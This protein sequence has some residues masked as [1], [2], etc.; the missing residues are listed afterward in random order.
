MTSQFVQ[1]SLVLIAAD[2][3]LTVSDRSFFS[4]GQKASLNWDGVATMSATTSVKTSITK[5]VTVSVTSSSNSHVL[6]V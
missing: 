2:P 4:P 5:S 1:I 3:S 6:V